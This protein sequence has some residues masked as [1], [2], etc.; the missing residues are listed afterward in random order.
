[1]NNI[2]KKLIAVALVV[3]MATGCSAANESSGTGSSVSSDKESSSST[4]STT[5]SSTESESSSENSSSESSSE[6]TQ[7]AS[8][9]VSSNESTS[10]ETSKPDDKKEGI[11]VYGKMSLIRTTCALCYDETENVKNDFSDINFTV[12][13]KDGNEVFKGNLIDNKNKEFSMYD[14]YAFEMQLPEW[15]EGS[16]YKIAFENLPVY[17]ADYLLA[18]RTNKEYYQVET[19]MNEKGKYNATIDMTYY[20]YSFDYIDPQTGEVTKMK[21][22]IGTHTPIKFSFNYKEKG[23]K[24]CYYSVLDENGKLIPN[25]DIVMIT[26]K[27]E[28]KT[29]TGLSGVGHMTGY[30]NGEMIKQWD[31]YYNNKL[32]YTVENT[33][34]WRTSRDISLYGLKLLGIDVTKL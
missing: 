32:I 1:M 6:S 33:V 7:S 26:D 28:Y 9:T 18:T 2:I 31:V 29:N 24:H 15:Q 13:D 21:Q 3:T 30:S 11:T 22:E 20:Y 23:Q 25:A 10:G 17:Y 19:T 27:G 5:I 4:E 16:S 8:E 14:G 34:N 12:F